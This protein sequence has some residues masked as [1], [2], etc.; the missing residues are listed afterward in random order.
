M[1]IESVPNRNS[2]PAILLRESYRDAGKIKKRTIA[3]L[4]DW[5]TEIVE[6]LRTLLK[7]GKVAPADQESIVV[8]RA[9][10]H[11]H[12]AAVLGTLRNIGLDRMLGPPRNRCRDL[13][14]AMIVA[15]LIA[16]ASKLATAR[17]L[18]PL[19]ASSSLGEVL[20]LGP[21]DE[22]ELYVALDWL[23]ERQEAIEKALARKHL[24]DGTLVLYDVSSS[25]VEGRCCELARLGY[26]RDGKK[27]KLQIV[28]GLLCAADGCPVAIEVFEGDT[29]DPRTLAAQIDKVKKRFALE[30]VALV[31]DRGM[32]TQA[33]LDAEI[34]PAGLDWITALRAPAIRTLVE[35]GALQMSLFDQR[36]MAAITSPDYP[37]E[38]LIVCRNPDLARERRRKR[39]DLL[40]ATEADLAV[41]AAAVRRARNPLRGEAEIALKAGAVVNRHKVAKHF[42]LSIGE[43]SF[44]FRRKTEAIAAE[45]ALDGIYVV[46][47]NLP[48]KLLDDAATVGAYKSLARVERAFRAL[49]TVDIHLRPIFHWT[50]P[51]VRAHVLLCM[52]AYHVEHHMRARLAPMLYDE[53]DHEAAAAMRASIV[54]KAERSEAARRKQTTGLT[55]DGLPVHSFQSLLADL[56]TYARIQATTALNDKYVFTLHTRPTPIQQRAFELLA[57]NPDRTQ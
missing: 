29:G 57:V 31:G 12:I 43:A 17:M 49:K 6:G 33:R 48:R 26:N 39:E 9:L 38:R 32:I 10:P 55:D 53:T 52:L 19:T 37:G 45:A 24:H 42:E 25:Y 3:N 50:T 16:P 51:R 44:S 15:R 7:G 28:Y 1:Y 36:D 11:G 35:A 34:A 40:A 23:G 27:G 13:V 4:S 22:D 2:P 56:A 21:V 54:A 20:G 5:P 18:D 30:R 47:T 41:I 8:R 14:I 46:R